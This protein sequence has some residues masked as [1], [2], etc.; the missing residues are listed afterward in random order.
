MKLINFTRVIAF[1]VCVASATYAFAAGVSGAGATFPYPIYAK[2]ADM[3]NKETGFRLNYQS[4]GSGGG[5]KQIKS[6]TVTFGAS[7]MPL[8]PKDLTASGLLQFPT[9]VGGDVPV[10]N[11]DGIGAGDLTLDGPT[12]GQHFPWQDHQVGRSGDQEAQ[13]ERQAPVE[14]DRCRASI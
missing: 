1:A 2:W 11:L 4:I 3:Y 7:D 13:P 9:V 6:K 5:I 12:L 8:E 14:R 10:V